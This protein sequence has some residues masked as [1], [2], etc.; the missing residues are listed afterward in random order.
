MKK[1]AETLKKV[2]ISVT[3]LNM[4]SYQIRNPKMSGQSRA[5]SFIEGQ[6]YCSVFTAC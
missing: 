2:L 1:Q 5:A 4:N 6:N 3:F